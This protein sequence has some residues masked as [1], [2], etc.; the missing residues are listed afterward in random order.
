MNI[1][2]SPAGRGSFYARLGDRQLCKSTTPFFDA[3]RVL[4]SEGADGNEPLTMTHAG[5]ETVCLRSTVQAAARLT[6]EEGDRGPSFRR[7][8]PFNRAE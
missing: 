8:R 1:T 5:S 7:Y 2:I 6:V 3:A 4:A